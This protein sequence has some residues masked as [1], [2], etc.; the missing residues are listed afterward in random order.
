MAASAPRT[1][2]FAFGSGFRLAALT[3]VHEN[4]VAWGPRCS[5]SACHFDCAQGHARKWL[6][7]QILRAKAAFRI[8]AGGSRSAL[9]RSRPQYRSKCNEALSRDLWPLDP[10]ES[11]PMRATSSG[12]CNSIPCAISGSLKIKGLAETLSGKSGRNS[13]PLKKLPCGF[14]PACFS[15]LLPGEYYLVAMVPRLY[16]TNRYTTIT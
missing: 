1:R 3:P 8:S 12:S 10:F 16:S 4:R 5:R 2:S 9:P 6:K 14:F 11:A 13:L 7:N 15:E